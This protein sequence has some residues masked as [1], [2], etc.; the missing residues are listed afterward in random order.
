M[1]KENKDVHKE[2]TDKITQLSSMID[3][4]K[5]ENKKLNKYSENHMVCESKYINYIVIAT[6]NMYS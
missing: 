2:I 1:E 6:Y 3:Q 5:E 4:L